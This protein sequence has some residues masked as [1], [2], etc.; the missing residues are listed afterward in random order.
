SNTA[1]PANNAA[2]AAK[3]G[4]ANMEG[5]MCKLLWS[6]GR[7]LYILRRV[8]SPAHLNENNRVKQQRMSLSIRQSLQRK[9]LFIT[10]ATGF[11]G[12]ALVEK[13]LRHVPDCRLTL[14]VRGAD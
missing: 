8:D 3:S 14:L 2:M 5:T 13:L 11:L 7:R 10:G 1:M 12:L 6:A 9:H 4:G